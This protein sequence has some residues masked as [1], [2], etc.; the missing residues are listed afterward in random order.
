MVNVKEI[1]CICE[2]K[3]QRD[4]GTMV[5]TYYK[6]INTLTMYLLLTYS[7]LERVVNIETRRININTHNIMA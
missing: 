5:V 1:I 4:E 3:I 2:I 7:T 6:T